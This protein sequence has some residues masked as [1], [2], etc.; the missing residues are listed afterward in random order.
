MKLVPITALA[1]LLAPAAMAAE[2]NVSISEDFQTKLQDDYG[3]REGEY[4][5]K[6]V[7]E[8]L[9]RELEKAGVD[10][11]RIDVT[12]LDAKPS[13]PTFKQLGDKPGLDFGASRSLGG[14][15]LSAVAYDAGDEKTKE[16]EYSWYEHDLRQ[17]GFTTWY[18]ANRA[19]NRFAR[20]FVE[21]LKE[22]ELANQDPS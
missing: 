20:N 1:L 14:M 10:V 4:L 8:D 2:I 12:I 21:D 3:T 15:K 11:A 13:K 17:T 16:Y 22:G 6:E 9:T 7:K 5:S 19:S 18:D